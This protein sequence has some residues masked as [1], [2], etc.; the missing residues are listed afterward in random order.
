MIQLLLEEPMVV[1]L[2]KGHAL[3]QNDDRNAALPLKALADETFIVYGRRYGPGLYDAR[4][5]HVTQQASTLTSVRK[6]RAS[7]Q[8]LGSLPLASA[9]L[10]CRLLCN[11]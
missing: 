3:A 2:P 6:H 5:L 10:W 1:V 8:R 9:S 7:P 4:L 11:E